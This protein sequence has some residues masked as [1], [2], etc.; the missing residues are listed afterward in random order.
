MQPKRSHRTGAVVT[1][2][3]ADDNQAIRDALKDVLRS[4]GVNVVGATRSGDEA[5]RLLKR[6]SPT[7]M[8]LD[9]RLGESSGLALAKAAAQVAPDTAV[10]LYTSY[11]D[12]RTISDA[13]AVGVRA[14]VFKE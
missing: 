10:I 13:L 12:P 5:I 14:V 11:A 9:L 7:V 3:I 1:C 8:I 4:A 2:L 6:H